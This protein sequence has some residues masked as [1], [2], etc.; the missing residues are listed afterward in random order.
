[1]RRSERPLPVGLAL[2]LAALAA[3]ART[4][5]VD[6][7]AAGANDGTSWTNAYQT[8]PPALAAAASGDEI[9]VAAAT[10]KPT[11]TTD[12]T[13]SFAL[14]NGVGV[15][16]GFA[17]TETLRIERDPAAHVTTLSGDIGTAASAADNSYHVVAA[18][19]TVTATGILDGFMIT[20][21]NAN[22]AGTNQ[23]RGAGLLVTGG[24]PTIGHCVFTGGAAGTRGGGVRVESGGATISDSTFLSNSSG[25]AGGGVSAGTITSLTLLRC[26]IRGNS[27]ADPARGGGIDVTNN[28][29]AIDCLIAQNSGNG[30]E[31]FQG[32]NTLI[33]S[34]VTGHPGYGVAVLSGTSAVANSILWGDA[35]G[36][37][38]LSG[39]LNATYSDVQ[40]GFGGTGNIN[41]DPLFVSPAS[42]D[43]RPG[44]GSPAIDAGNNAAVPVGVTSD[45]AGLPRFFDDPAKGDTG[46]GTPPIVDMGAY[47]RVPFSVTAPSPSPQT[48]CA[49][50]SAGFSVT[51]S[52]SG[53]FTYR[54]RRNTVDLSNGGAISG[55]T[56]A[57]LTIN[58]TGTGDSGS[59]DVRVTDSLSQAIL[60]AT[61]SL[62]VNAV[63]SAPTAGNN[64]PVCAGQTLQLTASTV[65]GAAYAWTGPNGFTSSVQNPSILSATAAASGIYSVTATVG[66]CASP[67]GTTNASV[68]TCSAVPAALSVNTAGNGVLEPGESVVVSPSW[69]NTTGSPIALTGAATAFT[70]P[71]GATYTRPDASASYG[72]IAAGATADCASTTADC[73]TVSVSN[74]AT[75]PVQH[76]DASLSESVS[77][78]DS[79]AWTVHIG[80]SFADVLASS[81]VYRFVET[82]LHD[83][84]TGGCG[85]SNFCP[86][87]NVS[88]QQMAVFL[89]V[90]R[91]GASYV[92][93]ACVTPV[94]NDVP[95]SN[96]FAKWID[97]LSN[98]GVTAGCG[99]GAYCPTADVTRAQ[100]AVFLLRTLEGSTYT[101]PACVTPAFADVPCSSGFAVWVD[102]LAARGI[103]AGCGGGNYCPNN[104]VT[105]G[106]MAVFL[107]TTFGLTLYGP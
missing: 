83:G 16:G 97:E 6:A 67:A 77:S 92:P 49:G 21:G 40:G 53:P 13:L 15:Y 71:A 30:V 26:L 23:D 56:T 106:Q 47:E 14:K 87:S 91:E 104:P 70:G 99:G 28:V 34:T 69:K 61:G 29:T 88:R 101:P 1:M 60:S 35:T 10:Y 4:I 65:A 50:Q 18:D 27:A 2:L 37:T 24:N 55:A 25:V 46:A 32:G 90:S 86:G 20:A 33:N 57:M 105:R 42:H 89:L 84:V 31:Y 76:W 85:G 12:R 17:G 41:A 95:C 38:F 44:A 100:M 93:P 82:L 5:F 3:Q 54:W 73:Y 43:W 64:G 98:R 22:G 80:G 94:F 66:G 107:T 59:Y 68:V 58:P 19:A 11:T 75:R 39:V 79:K 52:G 72:T 51:A 45:L 63:P 9:W 102:E 48:L 78:G 36:E 96:G 62:T 81:G 74:P 103:T 8:L 7:A